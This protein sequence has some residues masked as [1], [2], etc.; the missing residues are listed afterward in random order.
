MN[1]PNNHGGELDDWGV[2]KPSVR[3]GSLLPRRISCARRVELQLVLLAL[4][5]TNFYFTLQI[6]L[7]SFHG[8]W[9]GMYFSAVSCKYLPPSVIFRQVLIHFYPVSGWSDRSGSLKLTVA[10]ICTSSADLK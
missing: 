3:C 1:S 2:K 6:C 4:R 7:L 10:T 8:V 5:E 9:I